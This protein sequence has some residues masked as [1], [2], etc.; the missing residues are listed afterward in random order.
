M[1]KLM[2]ELEYVRAYI[3]DMLIITND[4][5][6]DH[7]EKLEAVLKRL[8]EAGLKVN[9][10]KSFL[11]K[12]ELEYLGYWITRDGIQPTVSKIQAIINIVTPRNRKELRRF[13]GLVNYCRDMWIRRSEFL[14]PLTKLTSCKEKW[15]WTK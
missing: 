12:G 6:E 15:T 11:A 13:I 8:D 14:A 5:F 7:M 4:S 9:A 1:S 2:Q 10:S 3:D